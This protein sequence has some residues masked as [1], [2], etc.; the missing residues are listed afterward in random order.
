MN[1]FS[2]EN[3]LSDANELPDSGDEPIEGEDEPDGDD[4][5]EGKAIFD[6]PAYLVVGSD[7]ELVGNLPDWVDDIISERKYF[8]NQVEALGLD[9]SNFI[10]IP[11]KYSSSELSDFLDEIGFTVS[12]EYIERGPGSSNDSI[13]YIEISKIPEVEASE[14]KSLAE[15]Q[16]SLIKE[17]RAELRSGLG[18]GRV[19]KKDLNAEIERLIALSQAESPAWREKVEKINDFEEE[20]K[21]LKEHL[22]DRIKTVEIL[23]ERLEA[24]KKRN[25]GESGRRKK[26]TNNIQSQTNR[27]AAWVAA[28]ESEFG[29]AIKGPLLKLRSGKVLAIESIYG[30]TLNDQPNGAAWRAAIQRA[31]P[32]VEWLKLVYKDFKG[33]GTGAAPVTWSEAKDRF[34]G[35]L[36]WSQIWWVALSYSTKGPGLISPMKALPP[37]VLVE[38][39]AKKFPGLDDIGILPEQEERWKVLFKLYWDEAVKWDEED[40]GG[41][42]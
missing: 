20:I 16:R 23:N 26:W 10:T 31:E 36:A 13:V 3:E 37:E 34:S 28:V 32:G 1:F 9:P 24:A 2:D 42:E 11:D 40:V 15:A 21:E 12:S 33:Y 14:A 6:D 22:D 18:A 30:K 4:E 35:R 41:E 27:Y 29:I 8:A 25:E 5:G 19:K 17:V 39:K 7:E 38:I